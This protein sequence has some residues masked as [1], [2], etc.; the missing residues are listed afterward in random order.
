MN[1]KIHL[2]T[3]LLATFSTSIAAGEYCPPIGAVLPPPTAPSISKDVQAAIQNLAS[4]LDKQFK[5]T[6]KASGVS[7]GVKSTHEHGLLFNYHYTPPVLS[8]IGTDTIDEHTIFRVGSVSKLVTA[9][10]A[11]QSSQVDMDASVLKYFPELGNNTSP[12]PI[13]AVQWE[14]VTVRSLASHLSGLATNS[15]SL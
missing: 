12:E 6:L 13:V 15:S 2:I 9:L 5:P 10:A 3:A 14:N 1:S 11:L 7:I 8:G 4:S